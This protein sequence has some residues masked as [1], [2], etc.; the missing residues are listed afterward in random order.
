VLKPLI[1]MNDSLE[2]IWKDTLGQTN[3]ITKDNSSCSNGMSASSAELFEE[4]ADMPKEELLEAVK[5][6]SL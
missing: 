6:G 4:A 1:K 3:A 5:N 2:A